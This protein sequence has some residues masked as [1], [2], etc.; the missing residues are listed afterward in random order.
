LP[1]YNLYNFDLAH[2]ANLPEG[3][4]ILLALISSSFLFFLTMS[5]AIQLFYWTDFHDFFAK[6]KVFALIFVIRSSFSDSTRDVAMATDF[7][8]KLW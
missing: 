4:Y 8:A 2:S 1:D 3:L 6:W 7:V 5:K